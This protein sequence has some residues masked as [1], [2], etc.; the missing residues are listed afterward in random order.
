M[1]KILLLAFMTLLMWAKPI[2]TKSFEKLPMFDN[3][4][5]TLKRAFDHGALYE[6]E[7]FMM[8]PQGGAKYNA[9]VTKD[10]KAFIMGNAFDMQSREA[11][12]M[13]LEVDAIK[14]NADFVYGK[15]K[16]ALIVV[17]DP[18]CR[19]CQQF[20]K[21]WS[22]LEARYT[23]YVYLYPMSSHAQAAQMS[24]YVLSQKSDKA[25]ADALLGI[26]NGEGE[27]MKRP[28]SEEERAQFG[29]K[30][31][32]NGEV[33]QDLGVRGTPSVFDFAGNFVNWSTLK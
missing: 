18:E 27:Y 14:K 30:F 20:Q 10:K 32:I 24:Y 8:T 25:K 13:P 23:F 5:I 28:F 17:T 9:F 3:P 2:D 22:G 1:K 15:G 21:R 26:A 4:N 29:Q 6:V 16:E 31:R 11:L 12:R 33:A 7:F 19:Y